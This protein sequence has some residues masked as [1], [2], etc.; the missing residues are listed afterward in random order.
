[1]SNND[2]IIYKV[3]RRNGYNEVVSKLIVAQARL[4]S[5]DYN[6]NVFVNNTN[7]SGMKFIGQPLAIR[8]TLAPYNERSSGCQA[9]TKGQVGGQGAYPCKDSDHYAKF[10]NV[11][12]SAKDKIERNYSRTIGGVTT[13]QLKSAKNADEFARL[14]KRRSYYGFGKEG[15]SQGEKEITNYAN[16]LTAKLRLIKIIEFIKENPKSTALVGLLI[17]GLIGYSIYYYKNIYNKI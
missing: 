4:E 6:S 2:N 17:F 3:A 10:K 14:L 13:E 12:D 11:E 15:T 9:V 16:L 1:M 5:S 7:T 8:G